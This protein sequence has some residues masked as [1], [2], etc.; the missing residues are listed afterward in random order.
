MDNP[1]PDTPIL[2]LHKVDKRFLGTHALKQVDLSFATAKSTPSWARTA[3][4]SPR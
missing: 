3:R 1:A 4:E 2:E